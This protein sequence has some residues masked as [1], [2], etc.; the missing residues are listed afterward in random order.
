LYVKALRPRSRADLEKLRK[1][2]REGAE[3]SG[4]LYT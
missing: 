3:I 4:L 2:R 1:R